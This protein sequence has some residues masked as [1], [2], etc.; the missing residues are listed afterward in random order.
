MNKK[1]KLMIA[2]VALLMMATSY[3]KDDHIN[4][5]KLPSI[6]FTFTGS[7]I[8]FF[9]MVQSITVD[10]GD[11][12]TEEYSNPNY[13]RIMHNYTDNT[14]RTVRILQAEDLTVFA[15]YN[16][17]L[18]SLDASNCTTLTEL[19]CYENQ[20]TSLDVSNNTALTFLQCVGNQLS[21]LDVSNNTALTFLNCGG[22]QLTS[23]DISNNTALTFLNCGVNQLS[24]LD[25]SKNTALT[26]LYCSTNQLI[27][28]D[29]SHNPALT[30]LGCSYNNLSALDLSHNPALGGLDCGYN[31][32]SADA[33]NEMFGTLPDR[34]D[35][36]GGLYIEGNPGS[37]TC[38]RSIAED[39]NWMF[40]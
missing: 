19:Y 26:E 18:T 22:N 27:S 14:V 34:Q 15:C 5:N 21:Y 4:N 24:S 11:E 23:L 2:A 20:L 12:S 38:T 8:E 36:G 31:N 10:W 39:K 13:N 25:V 35:T 37:A 28:L 29:V 32:L 6:E 17:R 40:W 1:I 16:Q 30:S 3:S 9:V 33:L 7:Y